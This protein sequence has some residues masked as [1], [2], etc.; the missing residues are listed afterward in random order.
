[1]AAA[2]G[3]SPAVSVKQIKSYSMRT[4]GPQQFYTVPF[5]T[6]TQFVVPKNIPLV[7]PLAYIHITWE[8][9]IVFAA[10]SSTATP[11]PEAPQSILQ[12][13]KWTGT[14]SGPN[15]P[16]QVTPFQMDGPTAFALNKIM[17][18]RP[19]L[20]SIAN[21]TL[22]YTGEV[23]YDPLELTGPTGAYGGTVSQGGIGFAQAQLGNVTGTARNIDVRIFWT[24]PV[25]P[26]QVSD[27]QALQ[28]LYNP[29][30]WGQTLQMYLNFGDASAL[31]GT[32]ATPPTFT[33]YGSASG[34]PSVYINLTYASLGPLAN[35]I[36]Q[37]VHVMNAYNINSTLA[38]TG[39]LVR[40]QLLQNQ[41]T[42]NVIKKIGVAATGLSAGVAAFASLALP[43]VQTQQTI[44]R[45]N[46]NP[47]RNL[48]LDEV[49][50]EFYGYRFDTELPPGYENYSFV[51]GNPNVNSYAA[52]KGDRLQGS[53]QFDIAANIQSAPANAAGIIVQDMIYGEPVIAAGAGTG[54]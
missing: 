36:R 48:Q 19:N 10:G 24:L 39:N 52:F 34:S 8:G 51:D 12:L 27:D 13:I 53:A 23:Y 35:S 20:I 38:A 22:S 49:S 15:M 1:M 46:N 7:Q 29:N 11:L 4:T 37:A 43:G 47:I 16:G 31:Y 44:L 21:S 14:A 25:F 6:L 5:S 50:R 42:L 26:F 18:V 28:F 33:A 54:S 45:V 3:T 41:R 9:R 2:V 32:V 30:T 40:L 17:G